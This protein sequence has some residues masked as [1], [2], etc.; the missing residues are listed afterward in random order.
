MN[1]YLSVD[2]ES[3]DCVTEPKGAIKKDILTFT[4]K[5]LLLLVCHYLSPT[6]ADNIITSDRAVFMATMIARFEVDFAWLL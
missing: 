1:L 5:F 3:S 2:G 4:A 6:T